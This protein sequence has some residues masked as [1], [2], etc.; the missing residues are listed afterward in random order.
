VE[1]GPFLLLLRSLWGLFE[2]ILR[3]SC[4]TAVYRAIGPAIPTPAYLRAATLGANWVHWPSGSDFG[5][6]QRRSSSQ[7]RPTHASFTCS[8]IATRYKE[9]RFTVPF[10]GRIRA[11]DD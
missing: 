3:T 2:R 7:A 4:I 1:N 9:P 5:Q 8:C 11:T 10:D 6:A